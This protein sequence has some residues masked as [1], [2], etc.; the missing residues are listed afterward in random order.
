M[1]PTQKTDANQA[2]GQSLSARDSRTHDVSQKCCCL[3]TAP[4]W[5]RQPGFAAGPL[6]TPLI[7]ALD[8]GRLSRA[9]VD[10]TAPEPLPAGH[11]FYSHPK[12]FLAPHHSVL[13]PQTPAHLGE[14]FGRN[15]Q[16]FCDGEPLL[17]RV[18]D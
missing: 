15:L 17:G 13:T 8:S 6:R 2:E 12:V 1:P 7:R 14:L 4:G 3:W 10:V 5:A 18:P 16:R 9:T 11:A